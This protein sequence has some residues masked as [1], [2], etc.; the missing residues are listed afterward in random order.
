MADPFSGMTSE[1]KRAAFVRAAADLFEEKGYASTSIEDITRSLGLSKGI[2][3][4]YWS[5]KRELISEIHA[6]V[7]VLHNERLDHILA[8]I[9]PPRRRLEEAVRS[10]L[11]VVIDNK[12]LIATLMKEGSYPEEIVEDRRSYTVRLQKLFDEGI[13]A[14]VVRD[15]D[16]RLLAFAVLGL[17]RSV[18]QWYRPGGRLSREE[19]RDT[20]VRFAVEGYANGRR[21]SGLPAG[22][23]YGPDGSA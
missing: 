20:F 13:S 19:V 9:A 17:C 18:V 14:G 6:R 22:D 3:Y 12:S 8:T 7:M 1:E 16:P 5:N 23:S 21:E 15:E 2:F 10:H 4:Y 11:D